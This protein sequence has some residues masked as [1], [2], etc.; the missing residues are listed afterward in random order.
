MGMQ[1]V[2]YTN[3]TTLVNGLVLRKESIK[4]SWFATLWSQQGFSL[5]I[6]ELNFLATQMVSACFIVQTCVNN[7]KIYISFVSNM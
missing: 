6:A 7:N 3:P 5:S 2:H 1:S 4:L